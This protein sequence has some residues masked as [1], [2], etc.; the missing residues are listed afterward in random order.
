MFINLRFFL[1]LLLQYGYRLKGG[2]LMEKLKFF[3]IECCNCKKKNKHEEFLD[4]M[5]EIIP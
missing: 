5:E 3:D 4:V 1:H 2:I